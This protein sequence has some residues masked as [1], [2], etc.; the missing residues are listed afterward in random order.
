MS[1]RSS[2]AVHSVR[3]RSAAWRGAVGA[4]LWWPASSSAVYFLHEVGSGH[5]NEPG[6]RLSD[7]LESRAPPHA[8]LRDVPGRA[9]LAPL[10]SSLSTR[11]QPRPFAAAQDKGAGDFIPTSELTSSDTLAR[12]GL[13]LRQPRRGRHGAKVRILLMSTGTQWQAASVRSERVH[14]RPERQ[15]WSTSAPRTV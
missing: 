13:G 11:K 5:G 6:R 15:F 7:F 12:L 14:Q 8:P 10:A 1:V 4:F 9:A 2:S 3:S